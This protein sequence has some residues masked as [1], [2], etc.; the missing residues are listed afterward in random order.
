[1]AGLCDIISPDAQY[2]ASLF[3]NVVIFGV[4]D[5]KKMLCEIVSY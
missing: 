2:A 4:N 1:M 5:R 3:G